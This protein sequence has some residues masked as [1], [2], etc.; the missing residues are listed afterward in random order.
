MDKTITTASLTRTKAASITRMVNRRAQSAA[1]GLYAQFRD[2]IH[3]ELFRT[4]RGQNPDES[5][6]ANWLVTLNDEDIS[7]MAFSASPSATHEANQP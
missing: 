7:R 6:V 5:T 3:R 1:N 2:A 4:F